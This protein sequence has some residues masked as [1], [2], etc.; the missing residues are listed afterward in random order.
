MIWYSTSDTLGFA[1]VTAGTSGAISAAATGATSVAYVCPY[2][3][4]RIVEESCY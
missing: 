2:Y 1:G 4:T 3:I